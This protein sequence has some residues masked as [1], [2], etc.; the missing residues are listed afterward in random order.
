[1][2][3]ASRLGQKRKKERLNDGESGRD[4]TLAVKSRKTAEKSPGSG[5][6]AED[7]EKKEKKRRERL[8]DGNNKLRMAHSSRL[9]QL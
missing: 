2:A 1:M 3:H 4:R 8:N 6:K 7:G 5:S 9:G